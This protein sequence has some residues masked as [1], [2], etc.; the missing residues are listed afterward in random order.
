M[1]R[2]LPSTIALQCFEAAARNESFSQAA[3]V[4]NLTQSAISRQIRLLEEFVEQPLFERARQRVTL[5]AA[6]Q[7]Y[8]DEVLPILQNLETST[9]K[10]RSFQT[11]SGG[12]NIG[13][14]PTLGTRWLLPYLLRFA[15]DVPGITTNT[16]TYLDNQ[17]FDAN[18][19]DIGIVQGNPPW[20]GARADWLM[21][22]ELVVTASPTLIT[23]PVNDANDLLDHRLLY[24]GT[25]PKSWHIWF[26]T[27]FQ[28]VPDLPGGLNFPQYEM[29]IEA[30]VAGYGVSILP[31]VLIQKELADGSL[32][33][34][35]PHIART[36]SAYYLL[37]PLNKVS[38]PKINL[39]RQWL[40]RETEIL[41]I[42]LDK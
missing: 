41:T 33:L 36:Q 15:N 3:R 26:E 2:T 1:R 39:F 31:L 42:P 17:H 20:K 8:F 4:L 32:C 5:T 18:I 35:H 34:A 30:T 40:L 6:G 11:L 7:L 27:L 12:L 10:L 9:L 23:K 13:C 38:M 24:H 29:V 14:Y 25:R 37:T 22:E 21:K 28:D 19:I 16:I